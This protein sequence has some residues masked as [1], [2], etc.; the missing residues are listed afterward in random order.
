MLENVWNYCNTLY[1]TNLVASIRLSFIVYL[2]GDPEKV[3]NFN[4]HEV[5]LGHPGFKG[6]GK[7][8][9]NCCRKCKNH[10]VVH[11]LKFAKYLTGWHQKLTIVSESPCKLSKLSSH[12]AACTILKLTSV[13]YGNIFLLQILFVSISKRAKTVF[14][15]ILLSKS[16]LILEKCL[17]F[18][19]W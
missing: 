11:F 18:L 5:F 8:E 16:D 9:S 15:S 6:Q 4:P 2:Q 14:F 12:H 1:N 7:E 10:F 19:Q 3:Y 17:F 13:K